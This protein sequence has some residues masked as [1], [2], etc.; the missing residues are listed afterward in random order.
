MAELVDLYPTAVELAGLGPVPKEEGLEGTSLVP[1]LLA[2]GQVHRRMAFSQFP[3]CPQYKMT[4]NPPQWE[5][6]QV[7]REN[8]TRMGYSLRTPEARYRYRMEAELKKS[9]WRTDLPM[10]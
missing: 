5:C 2:P 9:K 1:A 8:I 4:V 6:L 3:R 7:P 10:P